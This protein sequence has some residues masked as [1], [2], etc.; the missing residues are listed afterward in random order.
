[1]DPLSPRYHAGGESLPVVGSVRDLGVTVSADL[2]F[3]CHILEVTKNARSIVNCIFR[4]FVVKTPG[5]YMRLYEALIVSRVLYC[6]PVWMPHL[7]KHIRM[8]QSVQCYFLK[9]LHL[10]CGLPRTTIDLP[11]I[12]SVISDQD[13]RVLR[14]L[15]SLGLTDRFF[16]TRMNNLR[17]RCTVQSEKVPRNDTIATSFHG[18]SAR[19]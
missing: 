5:F 17:S 2:D 10:R 8:L 4:C 7:R 6:C 15:I 19:K 11:P 18:E 9:R 12:E 13:T 3:S 16:F 1:M 14:T